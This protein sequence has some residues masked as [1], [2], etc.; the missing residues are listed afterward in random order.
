MNVM[1]ELTTYKTLKVEEREDGIAIV[2]LN[3]PERL[4][5]LNFEVIE[6]LKNYLHQLESAYQVRVVVLTGEGRAF[7]AGLDLREIGVID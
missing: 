7:S 4:N 3:R 5:A 2:K 1:R 6:E